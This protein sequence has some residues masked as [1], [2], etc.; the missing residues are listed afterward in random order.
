M[1]ISPEKTFKKLPK[2]FSTTSKPQG[3]STSETRSGI[4]FNTPEELADALRVYNGGSISGSSATTKTVYDDLGNLGRGMGAA[5]IMQGG[6]HNS[7]GL[8]TNL[9]NYAISELKTN[10]RFLKG[11]DYDGLGT[12]FLKT[13]VR[14]KKINDKYLLNLNSAGVS[15]APEENL[16]KKLQRSQGLIQMNI[17]VK[18]SVVDDWWFNIDVADIVNNLPFSKRQQK[19]VVDYIATDGFASEPKLFYCSENKRYGVRVVLDVTKYT[20]PEGGQFKDNYYQN[21]NNFVKGGSWSLFSKKGTR[22][23]TPQVSSPKLNI[24]LYCLDDNLQEQIAVTD[25]KM[26]SLSVAATK[27]AETINSKIN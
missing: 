22:L 25:S 24:S 3:V 1:I 10:G 21:K 11:Y 19:K 6:M 14:G 27:L 4:L 12:N 7:N 2:S 16:A 8:V 15:S 17:S 26:N 9:M 5:I 13:T 20:R 23:T 18:L